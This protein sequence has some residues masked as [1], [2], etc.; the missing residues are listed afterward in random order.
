[1]KHYIGT[2]Q[3]MAEPMNEQAAVAKGFARKNTTATNGATA[4]TSST[5]T[6]TDPPTTL[7]RPGRSSSSPTV[8]PKRSSTVCTSSTM[9]STAAHSGWRHLSRPTSSIIWEPF[10]RDGSCVSSLPCSS[11]ASGCACASKIVNNTS[12][13]YAPA[14]TPC[15]SALQT[16]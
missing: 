6:P 1:M 16:P 12:S 8:S 4:I 7:G 13:P 11:T 14:Q 10:S 3:V 15:Q 2:K 5:P 9:N